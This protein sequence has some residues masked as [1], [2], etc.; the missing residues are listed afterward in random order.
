M[1]LV[2]V[3]NMTESLYHMFFMDDKASMAK[4]KPPIQ[5]SIRMPTQPYD[6]LAPIAI[7][8]THVRTRLPKK[9]GL[10]SCR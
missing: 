10:L 6:L 7:S 1:D 4:S 2:S 5:T 9:V 3:R 8:A